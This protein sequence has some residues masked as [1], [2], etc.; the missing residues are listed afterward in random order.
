LPESKLL[1][2]GVSSVF[3]R[4]FQFFSVFFSFFQFSSDFLD[5]SFV[6]FVFLS[7]FTPENSFYLRLFLPSVLVVLSIFTLHVNI[8]LN[9]ERSIFIYFL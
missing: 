9:F 6:S 1:F 4:F 3:F 2:V 8:R 7:D 5:F